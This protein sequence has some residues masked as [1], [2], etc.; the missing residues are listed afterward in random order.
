MRPAF[1]QSCLMNVSFFRMVVQLAFDNNPLD[2]ML[3][4]L[5]LSHTVVPHPH[6]S[7]HLNPLTDNPPRNH[8]RP[9]EPY[10]SKQIIIIYSGDPSSAL[11]P[12][13]RLTIM[14]QDCIVSQSVF[15]H[16]QLHAT[17]GPVSVEAIPCLLVPAEIDTG[18][19]LFHCSDWCLLLVAVE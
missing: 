10:V 3:V 6:P 11:I 1:Y 9:Y 14:T 5:P 17:R 16:Q 15:R 7:P 8:H 13:R 4:V 19:N 2:K 12:H 18:L